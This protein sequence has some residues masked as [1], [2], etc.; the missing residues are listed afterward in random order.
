M[1]TQFNKSKSEVVIAGDFNLD[2]LKLNENNIV[3]KFVDT[4]TRQVFHP[5]INLPQ[6]FRINDAHYLTTFIA[7]IA[8]Q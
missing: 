2:M 4:I 6:Y 1:L 7:N 8:L 5:T 3:S